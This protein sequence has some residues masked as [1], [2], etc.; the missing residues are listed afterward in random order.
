MKVTPKLKTLFIIGATGAL[1]SACSSSESTGGANAAN[2]DKASAG[3]VTTTSNNT[4][5]ESNMTQPT[6]TSGTTTPSGLKYE[7]IRV[8]NGPSPQQGQTV[9]VHYTGWLTNGKKF[10]SSVDRHEPFEFNI[11]TGQVIR[12]W[13]EGVMSMKV[14]GKRKL[15]IPPSLGYGAKDVGNGLIPPNS[16]LIFEVELLQLK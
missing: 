16:T 4:S 3:G 1:V 6:E 11:G 13:D 5:G 8:G 15:V 9:S 7:E 14:G 10:D 12:G 2:G